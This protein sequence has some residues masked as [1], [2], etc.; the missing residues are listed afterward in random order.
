MKRQI[1]HLLHGLHALTDRAWYGS[2]CRCGTWLVMTSVPDDP[3][4]AT[5]LPWSKPFPWRWAREALTEA[6]IDQWPR[7][8]WT[9]GFDTNA[10]MLALCSV[11]ACRLL[12]TS[13]AD[14]DLTIVRRD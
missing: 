5:V 4:L 7:S 10:S 8:T 9:V 3:L 13:L 2:S 1:D 12:E 6:L 14:G 11:K